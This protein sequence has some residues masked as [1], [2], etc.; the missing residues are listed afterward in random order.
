MCCVRL[1]SMLSIFECGVICVDVISIAAN[2][3]S[4]FCLT[5]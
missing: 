1:L 2:A 3:C 5:L 4:L